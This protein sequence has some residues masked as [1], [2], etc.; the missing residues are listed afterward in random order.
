[1]NECHSER[2]EAA[3][4]RTKSARP[5]FQSLIFLAILRNSQR[6]FAPL[7]SPQDES[8]VAD[9]TAPFTP[10][11]IPDLN[12]NNFIC[13]QRLT[14]RDPQQGICLAQTKK[15]V[16]FLTTDRRELFVFESAAEVVWSIAVVR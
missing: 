10:H 3:T 12:I 14:D 16:R 9:M 4:Q 15:R 6:C 1:M 13:F 8:A 11:S 7:N 2:S 5:G